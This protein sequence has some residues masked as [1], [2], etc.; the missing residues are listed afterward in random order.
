MSIEEA[1]KLQAAAPG[2]WTYTGRLSIAHERGLWW[3][4]ETSWNT[5][6]RQLPFKLHSVQEVAA[7]VAEEKKAAQAKQAST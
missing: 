7:I 2:S 5:P 1:E 4:M 3:S 6:D